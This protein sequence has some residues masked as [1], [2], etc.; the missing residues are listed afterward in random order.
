MSPIYNVWQVNFE[1][2]QLTTYLNI[3]KDSMDAYK[4][5][6][7]KYPVEG[8]DDWSEAEEIKYGEYL[9]TFSTFL[10]DFPRRL[11]SSFIVSWFSYIE[12]TLI[13]LCEDIVPKKPLEF[14]NVDALGKG[15][16]RVKKYL[17]I[18][19][20]YDIEKKYWNEIVLIS[21]IRNQIVHNGGK[22]S[23]SVEKPN[24]QSKAILVK[25]GDVSHYLLDTEEN[26]YSYMDKHNLLHF[27]GT[28]FI[29]PPLEFCYY[30][31]AFG[32][33]FFDTLFND[34]E[35]FEG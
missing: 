10:G 8:C 17:S 5:Q 9:D 3:L 12:D 30:L 27:Y 33:K 19:C 14:K 28:F 4:Q 22:F 6:L 1:N 20:D 32:R 16:F 23:F 2:E 7:E 34:L 15:I 11:Y 31:V 24:D 26:L 21:K 29:K 25:S 35:L 13:K 18:C